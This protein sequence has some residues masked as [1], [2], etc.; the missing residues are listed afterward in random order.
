MD[1]GCVR[2][3]YAVHSGQCWPINTATQ[4]S[5][6]FARKIQKKPIYMN[7]FDS[8]WISLTEKQINVLEFPYLIFP[9]WNWCNVFAFY[10]RTSYP[11]THFHLGHHHHCGI[12]VILVLKN[13]F[14]VK[15]ELKI[16]VFTNHIRR[17]NFL[18][19]ATNAVLNFNM[20]YSSRLAHDAYW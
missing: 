14:S 11:Y 7:I 9:I 8:L 3:V 18:H 4:V 15:D 6:R 17:L 16:L 12:I 1:G 10:S 19:L 20:A 5:F 2:N 13:Y